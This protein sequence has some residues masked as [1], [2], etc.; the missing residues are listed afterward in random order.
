MP[1]LKATGRGR[2]GPVTKA[3]P[4]SSNSSSV[5]GPTQ[6]AWK[7]NNGSN[8]GSIVGVN[9]GPPPQPPPASSKPPLLS[10]PTHSHRSNQV[11]F[12]NSSFKRTSY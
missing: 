11:Y 9:R 7:R 8:S 3:E 2:L 1:T 12:D 10:V 5:N 4:P 6:P